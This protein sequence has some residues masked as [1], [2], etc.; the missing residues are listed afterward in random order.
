MMFP[1]INEEFAVKESKETKQGKSFNYDFDKGDFVVLDGKVE[2]ISDLNS[3]R[4]WIRKILETEKSRFKIY[5]DEEGANYGTSLKSCINQ[6]FPLEF[7]K[8][9]VEREIREALAKNSA[10]K[11]VHSFEF[12]KINRRLICSFIVETVYGRTGGELSI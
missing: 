7:T 1:E 5:Q 11:L 3:I 10:I 9:E 8:I 12:N 6:G 2:V 4:V